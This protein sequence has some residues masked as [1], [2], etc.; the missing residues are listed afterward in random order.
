M[1]CNGDR[2]G[3]TKVIIII[4]VKYF[5]YKHCLTVLSHILIQNN[6]IPDDLNIGEASIICFYLT[7]V[8]FKLYIYILCMSV[9]S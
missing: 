4:I 8:N 3:R 1:R 5:K 7:A 6:S 9:Y 2:K